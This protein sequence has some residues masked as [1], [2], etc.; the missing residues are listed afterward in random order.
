VGEK[1]IQAGILEEARRKLVAIEKEFI[2]KSEPQSVLMDKT[3]RRR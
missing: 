2:C 1:E 3:T